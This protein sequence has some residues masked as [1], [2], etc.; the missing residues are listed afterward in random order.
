MLYTLYKKWIGRY[1]FRKLNIGIGAS[2]L[3]VFLLLGLV[4][5]NSFYDVLEKK[6]IESLYIRTEKLKIQILDS[7]ERF[8]YD[9]LSMHQGK[10]DSM[11][12]GTYQLFLPEHLEEIDERQLVAEQNY[13]KN[14]LTHALT[15]NPY[16]SVAM[17]YRLQDNRLFV[18][19]QQQAYSLNSL[20]DWESF[21]ET[22]PKAYTHPFFGSSD[23][24]F[25]PQEPML[26]F[27]NPIYNTP[28]IHPEKVY[29]YYLLALNMK[30]IINEFDLHS[31]DYRLI[32]KQNDVTL[33]DS[34]PDKQDELNTRNDLIT[35]LTIPKY[36]ISVF[37]ISHKSNL[38]GKL[39][40]ITSWILMILSVSWGA[41]LII[42][43]LI[44][45]LI[46][47][48]LNQ[49]SSH[50]KKVQINPFTNLLPVQGEDEI[51]D[52][53]TRFNRMTVEL[54]DHINQVYVAEIRKRNAE[55]IALKTQIHPHFLYNTL[56][57]LRM[58][59]VI[60]DQPVL[61]DRLFH[62]GKLYRWML[63]PSDELISIEEELVHTRY[64][65][66]LLML[67]KSSN[68]SLI[69]HSSLNL[70]NCYML[71]F[72]L[73]PII[74][75]AI[76]HGKLE[77]YDEPQIIISITREMQTLQFKIE[78]NG[79]PLLSHDHDKLVAMLNASDAFPEQ[80]LGLKNIHERIKLYYG[81]SFGLFL[82][83]QKEHS[84]SFCLHMIFPDKR[85]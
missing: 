9:A 10:A 63:Q 66:E 22:L 12:A 38:Q 75:N 65:L 18:E 53:L 79:Q 8:K 23:Q 56:E 40:D 4:T 78:N 33:L 85:N 80:H 60:S 57:S 27:I 50:F 64:Y 26:Y 20:F 51:S 25:S 49:M 68:I 11:Q 30:L 69:I 45:R 67:G 17:L 61:A 52:L 76:E 39:A 37:G 28:N 73:Q 19:S 54:Q 35:T 81:S 42:I 70:E 14:V 58:Q 84:Q 47:G 59:A 82:P 72:T 62:M 3:V 44:Q 6:E 83:K 31:S 7:I 1:I 15:R 48:R 5:Y 41:C 16:A 77:Q 46:V 24:Q 55:F 71:K 34:K 74:E 36:N 2:L 32:I 29:G 21:F 13:F 43:H